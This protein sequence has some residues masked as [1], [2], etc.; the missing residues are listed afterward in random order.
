M[1]S[2]SIESA[3]QAAISS[4]EVKGGVIC[5]TNTSGEFTYNAAVGERT[6]LSGEKRPQ[7]LDDMLYLAS[8]SKLIASIAALQCVDDGLL[9]LDGDLS[10]LAP[11]LSRLPVLADDTEG[12]EPVPAQRPITLA[13][14]LSH[15]SGLGYDILVPRLAK[16]RQKNEA[17][18]AEGARRPVEEAFAYPLAFQPGTGWMYSQGLDWAGRVVERVTGTT[19]GDHVRR[20]IAAPLG[21]APDDAQFYP[22]RGD[23]VRARLV[24]LNPEDPEGL[25][26]AVLGGSGEWNR[27]SQG[28]FGGHGLFMTGEGYVKVLRS[29]LANDGKLLRPGTVEKMFENQIGPDAAEGHRAVVHDPAG[30]YYRVGVDVD[31]KLGYGLG[32]LL[33][34][35]DQDGW[36]GEK[37]MT[38]GGGMSLT[39]FI[40]RKNDLCGIGAV[41]PSI[42]LAGATVEGLKQTF[43]RDIYRKYAAW[44]KGR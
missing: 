8:A 21:I 44:K 7:K 15:T 40:D 29:L 39:W 13:M 38:W 10:E 26:R 4:G 14:L 37:T 36:Y 2:E 22:V 9:S 16:W 12:A 28:D 6:L 35:E 34:L 27:R 5:A 25:G 41:Q 42:P 33:T 32:G 23:G 1:A 3:F 18:L 11:E 19:L 43:R 31:K 20:R 30:A 17:P 24:D